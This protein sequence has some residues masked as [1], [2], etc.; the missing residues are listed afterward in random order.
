MR[1]ALLLTVSLSRAIGVCTSS[2]LALLLRQLLCGRI[3]MLPGIV[4]WHECSPALI[5]E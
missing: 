4:V 1:A 5:E 2:V 3:H